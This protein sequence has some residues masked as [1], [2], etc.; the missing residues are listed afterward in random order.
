MENFGNWCVL[1]TNAIFLCSLRVGKKQ[2]D[3]SSCC[4]ELGFCWPLKFALIDAL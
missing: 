1:S 3:S 4:M 2:T